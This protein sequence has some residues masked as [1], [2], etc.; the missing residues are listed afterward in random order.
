MVS[1]DFEQGNVP[2][3]EVEK[4]LHHIENIRTISRVPGNSNYYEKDGI[5]TEG[6]GMDHTRYNPV[7]LS[8]DAFF[9]T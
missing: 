7:R 9:S 6:D 1:K 5:R 3:D 8:H 2:S 4:S